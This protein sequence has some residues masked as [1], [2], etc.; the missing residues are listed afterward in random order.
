MYLVLNTLPFGIGVAAS[1]RVGNL[2]GA[3]SASG[4]KYAGHAS[5]LLSVMVGFVVM[6]TMLAARDVY[7][8]I[9]SDD[10]KVVRLVADIMPLVASFQVSLRYDKTR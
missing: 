4:A 9:F 5:A 2:I 10:E 6:I 1:A 8:Y 7:G 3:R